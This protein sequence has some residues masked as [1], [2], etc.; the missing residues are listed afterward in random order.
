MSDRGTSYLGPSYVQTTQS[1]TSDLS[2]TSMSGHNFYDNS[3][4]YYSGSTTRNDY[5][6]YAG[7]TSNSQHNGPSTT[8]YAPSDQSYYQGGQ[9]SYSSATTAPSGYYSTA[10]SHGGGEWLSTNGDPGAFVGAG[11]ADYYYVCD[12]DI[13]N[14]GR[15]TPRR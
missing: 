14:T 8:S 11:S 15:T 3:R 7:E 6:S 5:R 1:D 9:S 2:A 12:P 13:D 4:T 10:T